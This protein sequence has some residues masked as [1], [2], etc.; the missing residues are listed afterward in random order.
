MITIRV[1]IFALFLLFPLLTKAQGQKKI[2]NFKLGIEFGINSY[3][4]DRALPERIRESNHKGTD[5]RLFEN[6]SFEQSAEAF[7][8]GV[9][10]EIF[11]F[12]NRLGIS[13]GVRFSLSSSTF[14]AEGSYFLWLLRQKDVRTDYVRISSLAQRSYFIGVP[15]EIRFF[16]APRERYRQYYLKLGASLNYQVLTH[17]DTQFRDPAMQVHT[18]IIE[19]QFSRLSIFNSYFYPAIGFKIGN[20]SS[21]WMNVEVHFPGFLI[22]PQAAS[23]LKTGIGLGFQFSIQIPLGKTVPI[24]SE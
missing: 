21:C 19:D 5:A 11:L 15:L 16:P 3:L 18:E 23:F 1:F 2:N 14:D 17:C 6:S 8:L 10:P 24:G 9:K 7:Y 12:K 4:G 20:P 22:D 13:S